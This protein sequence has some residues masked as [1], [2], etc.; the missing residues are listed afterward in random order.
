MPSSSARRGDLFRHVSAEK[1]AAYRAVMETFAQA[2]R[3]FRLHLRPDEI[4]AEAPWPGPAPEPA[5]LDGLLAQLAEW[6][7]LQAQPDTARVATLEDFYRKRLLFRLSAGGEA[8]EVG[9][10]AFHEALTRRAELQSVALED[11]QRYLQG[12]LRLAAEQPADAAKVRS[13]LTALVHEFES[14]A[15]N[16]E[17]FMAGLAR[18]IELQRAEVEAVLGF[19]SRLI[20]YLE[21]FIGDLVTRSAGIARLLRQL[22]PEVPR[23]LRLAAER[24]ARD[25]APGDALGQAEA[26]DARDAAWQER[27]AGFAQWFVSAGGRPAQ[28]E[29]LRASARSAIPRLLQAVTSLNER[30][31]GRS[32]RA[33]DFRRLA[34]WFAGCSDE[35]D[36]HRLWR[37]AFGL[38]PARH[39]GLTAPGEAPAASLP[40]RDA[41]AIAL[42]PKLREQGTLPTRGG[43]PKILD[44]SRERELLARRLQAESAQI[45]AARRRLAQGR[46]LRLSELGTL[47]RQA[48][49]LFLNLLGDALAAQH[50]PQ[51]TVERMSSDGSLLIRLEP[52]QDASLAC[53][54]TEHGRF[55]GRDHLV[56]ISAT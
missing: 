43:P 11:I 24:E 36:A 41:P 3:Q 29:L 15:E 33:A 49:G 44:R 22:D 32:D 28:A 52:L 34:V 17:A 5:E 4:L 27:W 14:L 35:G 30:R 42:H 6:G 38:V 48:F 45:D 7:N 1:A 55:C 39:L 26:A 19:K 2:K 54:E 47:D 31:A 18:S 9:L 53:I 16:A 25:A 23:L 20:E 56:T 51:Q 37:C 46:P 8:V 50:H 10:A 21:R 40:W 13:A 12:L